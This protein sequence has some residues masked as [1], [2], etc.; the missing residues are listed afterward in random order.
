MFFIY[1]KR[2]QLWCGFHDNCSWHPSYCFVLTSWDVVSLAECRNDC[3]WCFGSL[4]VAMQ[5]VLLENLLLVF[6]CPEKQRHFNLPVF[7]LGSA[8]CP[9]IPFIHLPEWMPVVVIL[10]CQ[11]PQQCQV[12]SQALLHYLVSIFLHLQGVF[13]LLP[14]SVLHYCNSTVTELKLCLYLIL[15]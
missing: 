14:L 9:Q 4:L 8:F 13:W 11:Y 3:I 1:P 6:I 5:S 15:F 7:S 10:L 2:W 12:L